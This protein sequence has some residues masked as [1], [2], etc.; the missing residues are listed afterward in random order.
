MEPYNLA[1]VVAGIAVMGAAV[2]PLVL[3]NWPLSVPILFVGLGIVV[4]A[5]P[6]GFRAPH[7]LEERILAERLTELV[8]IVSLMGAGLKLDRKIGLRAWASTWALLAV[9]MPLTI[10]L[11]LLIG[12]WGLELTLPVAMLLGAVIAPTDPVLASEVQVGEPMTGERGQ[13]RKREDEVRFALTSEAGLNDG[14]AFPFTNLAI[15]MAIFG[16]APQYWIGRWVLV[17]L[18]YKIAVGLVAGVIAGRSLGWFIF[19]SEIGKRLTQ[20]M[21]GSVALAATFLVYGAAEL[22]LGY[23]FLAV[24]VAAVALRSYERTHE[25][26]VALHDFSQTIEQLLMA[27]VLILFGG[28][29]V[30]GLFAP[31]TWTAALV[32]L[33]ILFFIRPVSAAIGMFAGRGDFMDRGAIAFFGIRGVGSFYYLAHGLNEAEFQNAELLWSVVGFVV[34]VSILVH[35][36]TA[37]PV[38]NILDRRRKKR[39]R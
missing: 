39:N 13:K 24:F 30:Y 19:S 28:S 2:L 15:A 23:G 38:M 8:V 35:G 14:L 9:T 12:W 27:L 5:L 33:G 1:L 20:S 31:L 7:P 16:A 3:K 36:V 37:S 32:G 17:D 34:L 6:L 29:I 18:L 11:T 4:F 26:H 22:A 25:Y 10:V 21:Q